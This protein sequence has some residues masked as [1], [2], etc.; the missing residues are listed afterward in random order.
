VNIRGCVVGRWYDG[1][2]HLQQEELR[3]VTAYVAEDADLRIVHI[4]HGVCHRRP[5][6]QTVVLPS[7]HTR[8][9]IA[10]SAVVRPLWPSEHLAHS[11]AAWP[12]DHL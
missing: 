8:V 12:P 9:I 4:A 10:R 11:G 5:L 6:P 2:A 1:M 3:A 7:Y